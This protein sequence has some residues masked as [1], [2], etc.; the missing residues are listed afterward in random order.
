[1]A[2]SWEKPGLFL[3]GR[4]TAEEEE[5][6]ERHARKGGGKRK[7]GG[8]LTSRVKGIARIITI[9]SKS[10]PPARSRDGANK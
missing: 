3:K 4:R 6:D 5:E 7:K 10:R 1:M 8:P 2:Y 9:K